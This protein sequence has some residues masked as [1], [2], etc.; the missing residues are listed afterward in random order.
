VVFDTQALLALYLGEDGA[1]KVEVHLQDVLERKTK[2][3]LNVVN[4]AELHY[5]LRR[6][7]REAAEEK[8]RNLRG[9]GVKVVPIPG[10]S[11]LWKEA[12]TIKAEHAL[13]LADA[14]AAATALL[15]RGTLLTGSDTEF[16]GIKD[17]KLERTG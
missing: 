5:I 12:A 9:F 8:E 10:R 16:E 1:D 4:L 17:L 6:A 13:S 2:G 15:Y 11:P 7:G 14:F 3:Y